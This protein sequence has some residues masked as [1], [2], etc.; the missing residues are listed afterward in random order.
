MGLLK[1]IAERAAKSDEHERFGAGLG[2][3][4]EATGTLPEV[5]PLLR[6]AESKTSPE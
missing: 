1:R 2:I 3:S 4:Y 5:T 6:A